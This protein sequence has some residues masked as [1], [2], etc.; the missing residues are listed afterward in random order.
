MRPTFQRRT[1]TAVAAGEAAVPGPARLRPRALVKP[2]GRTAFLK[3]DQSLHTSWA[4]C[5]AR[6]GQH[7][8]LVA[9]PEGDPASTYQN[10]EEKKVDEREMVRSRNDLPFAGFAPLPTRSGKR[11]LFTKPEDHD[12]VCHASA[13]DINNQDDLAR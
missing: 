3:T 13:W 5:G 11:S 1:R 7:Y 6:L 12:V 4:I 10:L 2:T 9:P 8:P